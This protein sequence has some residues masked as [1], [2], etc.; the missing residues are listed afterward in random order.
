MDNVRVC[1][2][3]PPLKDTWRSDL[4]AV[5]GYLGLALLIT[6]PIIFHLHHEVIG[7]PLCTN[8]MHV[9]VLWI[10]KQLL[11]AGFSPTVTNYIFY[12]S[13]A[14]MVR[15]YGSDLL[16]PVVLSPLVALL[17]AGVVFNLKI[18]FSFTMAP[19]GA[20]KLARHL[21]VQRVPA[22]VGGALFMA[23][24]YF[25]LETFNG[26]SE[27]IAVEW[28]PFFALYLMRS[29]E[30]GRWRDSL[31][32]VLFGLLAAYSSGYNIFFAL[33]FGLVYMAH[34]FY[35][36]GLRGG[37][38]RRS[39]RPS[40]LV[41]TGALIGVGLVP[42]GLLHLSG[43]T[44]AAVKDEHADMLDPAVTPKS[45]ASA[46]VMRFFRPGRNEI[47]EKRITGNGIVKKTNTTYTVYLGYGLMALALLG[48]LRGGPRA[49]LWSLT[50][51]FFLLVCLG[52]FLHITDEWVKLWGYMIP[53][54][55]LL[56]YK[57]LPG[58]DVTIRHTYRYVAMA[59]LA[60]GI[61]A[62]LGLE[63][64]RGKIPSA[65]ARAAATAGALGLCLLEVLA[66]GPTP[67]PIPRASTEVPEFY[68]QLAEDGENYPIVD[69][70]YSDHLQHLQPLLMAQTVHGKKLIAGAVEFRLTAD[71]RGFIN[72]VPLA[73]NFMREE[74]IARPLNRG[75]LEQSLR[76][77]KTAKFRY[78]LVRDQD[79]QS[80]G[81]ASAANR[82][83]DKIFGPPEEM[84]GGIK[85]YKV[86]Q[87]RSGTST[88]G[89]KPAR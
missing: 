55:G 26:V 34:R 23:S 29:Q 58:F 5:G 51:C 60:L 25:L 3:S 78:I 1:T 16:Y 76:T 88:P 33:L 80:P 75:E 65:R 86:S 21:G 7:Y 46:A 73:Q 39:F 54:P 66:V 56:L 18:L 81:S 9:W 77:L 19:L 32:C 41:L 89:A 13:G 30:K 15:L 4:L 67:W 53:M 36:G 82:F 28:V 35:S 50:A 10:V 84:S 83:L 12:P 6:W 31:L 72:S 42:L 24:S 85:V 48:A 71:E 62:A 38:W 27:L 22:W 37:A 79:F 64:L 59:H 63:W 14:D 69:L 57:I 87:G 70:P 68:H 44:S 20:Y 74:D 61:L 43:G 17:S 8:R 11:F 49:N 40:H 47:P 45:D 52:P 2:A